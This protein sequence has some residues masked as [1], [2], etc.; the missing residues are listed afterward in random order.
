MAQT[1]TARS[2]IVPW[3][4]SAPPPDHNSTRRNQRPI[5]HGSNDIPSIRQQPPTA[6]PKSP[7]WNSEWGVQMPTS[8]FGSSINGSSENLGQ[9]SPPG[10]GRNMSFYDD[11]RRPSVASATTISSTGSKSSVNG[12]VHKKL[13]SFF[14][15]EVLDFKHP[16]NVSRQGSETNSLRGSILQ[17]AKNIASKSRHH[18][19]NDAAHRSRA[20]SPPDSRPRSPNPSVPK[21]EV[22][23]WE[24]QDPQASIIH[25]PFA[26]SLHALAGPLR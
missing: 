6:R 8:V 14:G 17:G 11:E 23:P 3:E 13:Q 26:P 22:T 5:A 2:E 16:D 19:G 10:F 24:F 15:E 9:A 4:D 20:S 18:S 7:P 25:T 12:R 21:Q 1:D